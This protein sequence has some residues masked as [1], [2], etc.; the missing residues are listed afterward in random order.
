MDTATREKRTSNKDSLLALLSDGREHHQR[1]C[2]QVA[3]FRYG[4]RVFELRREG[5]IIDTVR[6]GTDAF[7]Y[8]MLV[9]AKQ[10]T[11]I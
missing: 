11:L 9:E 3:G 5:Y 1:E 7:A 4:A 10:G 8:R 2:L 6:I